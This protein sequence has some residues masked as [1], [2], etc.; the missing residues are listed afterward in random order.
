LGC[1]GL[2]LLG[3]ALFVGVLIGSSGTDTPD[4]VLEQRE[5][6]E[7]AAG[8]PQEEPTPE[9][10]GEVA[11]GDLAVGEAA[12]VGGVR[13][14][15]LEAFRTPADP[16]DRDYDLPSDEFTFVVTRYRVQNGSE[17]EL[18]IGGDT[19]FYAYSNTG[20]DVD[21][22]ALVRQGQTASPREDR[23]LDS[24]TIRVGA[25]VTGTVAYMARRDEAVSVEFFLDWMQDNPDATWNLGPVSE[26]PER[27]FGDSD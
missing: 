19:E 9:P 18:N 13:V 21:E 5:S 12:E 7:D 25:D 27:Q 11:P 23:D 1:G 3:V 15:L 2:A 8:T 17:K 16:T 10:N 26:L 6:K 22:V 20:A 4:S 24:I 14:T